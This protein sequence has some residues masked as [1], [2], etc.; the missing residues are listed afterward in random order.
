MDNQKTFQHSVKV[1]RLFKM[2]ARIVKEAAENRVNVKEL[3]Y[4]TKHTVISF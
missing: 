1:P 3:V 2:A 4:K